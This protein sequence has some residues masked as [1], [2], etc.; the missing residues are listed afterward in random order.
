M[1]QNKPNYD[2]GD[3][4]FCPFPFADKLEDKERTA[5]VIS[6]SEFNKT[7][8]GLICVKIT[9]TKSDHSTVIPILGFEKD[10]CGLDFDSYIYTTLITTVSKSIISGFY[11]TLSDA[12]KKDLMKKVRSYLVW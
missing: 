5:V 12:R 7:A 1:I 3:I 2:P 11:G 4:I 10:L 6:N 8:P 9:K